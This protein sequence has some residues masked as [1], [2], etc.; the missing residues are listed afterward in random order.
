MFK[1]SHYEE[2]E[3]K[4]FIEIQCQFIE[5]ETLTFSS[6]C[7][8]KTDARRFFSYVA[9]EFLQGQI[10]E[11][12]QIVLFIKPYYFD[13]N[14][15]PYMS[16]AHG[17]RE[18]YWKFTYGLLPILSELYW[19]PGAYAEKVLKNKIFFEA[20]VPTMVELGKVEMNFIK[21][22]IFKCAEKITETL[23]LMK[24]D[25]LKQLLNKTA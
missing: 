21:Q 18:A 2:R 25:D 10:G 17:W 8:T 7:D 22:D 3:G 6:L 13:K 11:F 12:T 15:T 19:Q 24:N 20:L 16:L 1:I 9:T 23:Q 14:A 4:F 5:K